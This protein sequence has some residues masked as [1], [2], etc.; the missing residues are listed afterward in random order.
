M[1]PTIGTFREL[2]NQ[3]SGK[4]HSQGSNGMRIMPL[5]AD[6][7]TPAGGSSAPAWG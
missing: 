6:A 5:G 1:R 7:V 2:P 4:H 3:L